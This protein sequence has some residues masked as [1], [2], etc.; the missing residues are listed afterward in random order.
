M[1]T[2]AESSYTGALQQVLHQ[3]GRIDGKLDAYDTRI[4]ALEQE[5]AAWRE[6]RSANERV[7]AEWDRWRAGVDGDVESLNETRSVGRALRKH[8]YLVAAVVI[9]VALNTVDTITRIAEG[10][11][12]S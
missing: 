2:P 11:F 3:L 10:S 9:P 12:G 7:A 5:H 1:T 6:L 8:W 4:R